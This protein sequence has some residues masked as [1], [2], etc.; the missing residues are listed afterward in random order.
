MVLHGDEFRPAILFGHMLSF[1]ELPGVHRR[2]AD[3]TDLNTRDGIT[4]TRTTTLLFPI[5]LNRAELPW[6]PRSAFLCR[7]D[8]FGRDRYN[9][10]SIVSDWLHTLRRYV[11]GSDPFDWA[12]RAL[13][14]TLSLQ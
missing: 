1:G 10:C 4:Q 2:S 7:I 14:G 5:E 3:V 13:D 8:G 12:L 11:F 9:R 6:S